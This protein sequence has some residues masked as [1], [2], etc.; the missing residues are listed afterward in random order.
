MHP[1]AIVGASLLAVVLLMLALVGVLHLTRGTPVERVH[2]VGDPRRDDDGAPPAIGDPAFVR[3]ASALARTALLPGHRVEVLA[4]G[5]GTVPRLWDDLRSATRSITVQLYYCQPSRMA[6]EFAEILTTRA[7]AGVDVRFI[8]DA[9]GGQNLTR[10]YLEALR[11]AGV[12]VA[13]L[14]PLR[15]PTLLARLHTAQNR[16]HVRLVVVDGRIG[17]TGGFGLDD[18]WYGDGRHA[19]EWRD[20]N[21]R[22]TGPAA[23]Q[24]QA[25]F[26]AAWA[27]ATGE[28]LLGDALF[29]ALPPVGAEPHDVHGGAPHDGASLDGGVVAGL[30]FAT[31]TSGST[32]AE[33]FLAATIACARERL[34]IANG[35]FAPDDDFRR[36]LTAAAARRVD[37]RILTANARSDVKTLWYAG[38]ARYEELLESGV[39]IWEYEPAMMHAKSLVA[40]G[41]WSTVGSM[42][43]DNRALALND[44]S[45]LVVHDATIGAQLDAMFVDD[46]RRATEIRLDAWRRRPW[47][48]RALEAGANLLSRTL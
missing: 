15:W 3:T 31:P 39:R 19:A 35:Y 1:I 27:E 11:R 8:F 6:D 24:F 9:F 4:N 25:A 17:Y 7:R 42:S 16:S 40:D 43:F 21:V 34:Y 13:A 5:E 2:A 28:L 23:W 29:P 26:A 22:C 47:P 32:D 10:A 33:R 18:K 30:L 41:V 36:L 14:R 38:R 20:T 45:T 48:G 46:L 37:V 44:E 12:R